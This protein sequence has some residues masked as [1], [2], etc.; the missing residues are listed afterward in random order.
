MAT[1]YIQ[2]YKEVAFDAGGGRIQAGREPAIAS[3]AI[4]FT[5]T[6]GLSAALNAETNF[7]RIY[8][9]AAAFLKFGTAP[10]AVTGTDCPVAADTAE[11]FGVHGGIK[12]SAV[13]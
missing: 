11:Y 12:I 1:L 4:S 10:V 13:V 2:E 5:G 3:Q 6:A 8:S 7:V 9:T